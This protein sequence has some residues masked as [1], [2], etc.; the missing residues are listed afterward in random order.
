MEVRIARLD[1]PDAEWA[2]IAP[3]LP[4]QGRGA[5][6]GDDRKILNGIFDI[7]LTGPP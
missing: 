2:V 7:L 5:R 3:L 6:R 1:L 4:R